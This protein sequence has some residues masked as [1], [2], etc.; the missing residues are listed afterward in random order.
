M[1]SFYIN[2]I[3]YLYNNFLTYIYNFL[4]HF[5]NINYMIINTI[6][7]L[8][9]FNKDNSNHLILNHYIMYNLYRN[10]LILHNIY[11]N[12][13]ITLYITF[14]L[15][16]FSINMYYHLYIILVYIYFNYWNLYNIICIFQYIPKYN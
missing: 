4:N 1:L 11:I 16:N 15:M 7:I 9:H 12:F 3:Y 13:H 14:H 2:I 10:Y 8:S 5:N 6:I